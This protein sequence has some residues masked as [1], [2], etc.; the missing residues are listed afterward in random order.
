[1]GINVAL[2]KRGKLFLE[3]VIFEERVYTHVQTETG[4]QHVK[5]IELRS[6]DP[7]V[8]FR[9]IAA[10][11][12]RPLSSIQNELA[13]HGNRKCQCFEEAAQASKHAQESS[14]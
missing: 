9:R 5:I 8:T 10:D 6:A 12:D 13:K 11:L 3:F 14:I 4:R 1:M 2:F 7:P